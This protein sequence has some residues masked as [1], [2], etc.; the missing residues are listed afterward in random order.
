MQEPAM[1][2]PAGTPAQPTPPAQ[3]VRAILHR[4][5]DRIAAA[6]Q[7]LGRLDGAVGD[8]DHGAGMMRGLRAAVRAV[9]QA[10]YPQLDAGV[11]LV[12]AGSA[13]ADEAGG[14]SGALVGS[15]LVSVGQALG[16]A[17]CTTETLVAA[18]QA[19]L[20]AITAM[21]NAAVGDKTL[22]DTLAPFVETLGAGAAAGL[23]VG[24]AWRQALPAAE[25]GAQST[26][27]LVG[28]RGR[29]SRL[30]E[31][32]RGHLDPGAISML[33]LLQAAGEVLAPA[34]PA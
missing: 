3:Q 20:G 9:D 10:V 12:Q 18:L 23:P 29:S 32:S 33:Y 31:R 16:S 26:A 11:L 22:V 27:A 7:E 13:F 24:E 8:G 25:A 1:S 2:M 21:G 6:E 15:G 17:G 19:G 34:E 4:M 5:L 30:G 14:A 28:R